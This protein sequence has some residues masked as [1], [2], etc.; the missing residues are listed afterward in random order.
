MSYKISNLTELTTPATG[1]LVPIID[2][3]DTTQAATGTTKKITKANLV[4]DK[5]SSG[6]NSDITSLA[7]LTTPLSVPQGGTGAATLDAAGIVDKASAQT[8]AG[9]K[10]FGAA[11]LTDAIAEKTSASGVTVD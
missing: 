1:D 7:G 8:I 4:A 2:L 5:A 10:T 9:V 11:P 3:S 6:A